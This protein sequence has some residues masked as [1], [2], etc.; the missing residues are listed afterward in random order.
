MDVD[1]SPLSNH[2]ESWGKNIG[3]H[4]GN[5]WTNHGKSWNNMEKAWEEDALLFL[6]GILCPNTNKSKEKPENLMER[7]MQKSCKHR[8]K[9]MEKPWND[10]VVRIVN[11]PLLA[12]LRH[13]L[14]LTA[15]PKILPSAKIESCCRI[16]KDSSNELGELT[17][18]ELG[19]Q[20][21]NEVFSDGSEY[22]IVSILCF[23]WWTSTTSMVGKSQ[24]FM[25]NASMKTMGNSWVS[26][27]TAA[28]HH[29]TWFPMTI[30]RSSL[31]GLSVPYMRYTS[32]YPQRC[33]FAVG[34]LVSYPKPPGRRMEAFCKSHVMPNLVQPW[35][36]WILPRQS[37]MDPQNPRN[38]HTGK[39]HRK[40]MITRGDP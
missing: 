19:F 30:W 40:W 5:S 27:F 6:N 20:H 18:K 35:I 31:V 16:W 9:I 23:Y 32:L 12:R 4:H 22:L 15:R 38:V 37:N 14:H 25:G 10:S 13:W 7:N 28:A 26:F 1:T 33:D 21:Q 2:E 3:K 36:S 24:P 39:S 34:N 17:F 29:F 11:Q 8:A